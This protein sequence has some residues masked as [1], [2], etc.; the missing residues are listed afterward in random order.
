MRVSPIAVL[1]GV[2]AAATGWFVRGLQF[3]P[4]ATVTAA[5]PRLS[6]P[7]T[8]DAGLS[9]G[10]VVRKQLSTGSQSRRNLFVYPVR[11]QPIQLAVLQPS[12]PPVAMTIAHPMPTVEENPHPRFPYSYIG[13]FGPDHN[14]VAAFA[15]DGDIVTVRPGDRIDRHFTLRTIGIESVEVESTVEGR[16][17]TQRILLGAPM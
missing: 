5:A 8:E 12:P 16:R 17:D 6:A 9:P 3:E 10:Q 2:L 15:R 4:P 7:T 1:V 13:R 14:P 11:E